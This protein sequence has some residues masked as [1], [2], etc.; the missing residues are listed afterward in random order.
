V[1]RATFAGIIKAW[2]DGY[3]EPLAGASGRTVAEVT[4][5]FESIIAA[6]ETPPQ[7]AVWHVPVISGR[8]PV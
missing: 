7:Y 8:K 4:A 2:R 1:P 3:A 6:I 5:D